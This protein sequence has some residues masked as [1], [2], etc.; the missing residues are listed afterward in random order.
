MFKRILMVGFICFLVVGCSGNN[1]KQEQTNG[2]KKQVITLGA[3]IIEKD[4]IDSVKTDFEE[5]GYKLENKVFDDM[6]TPNVA[7]QDGEI[8]A[9]FYQFIPYLD[10][11]NEEHKANLVAFSTP[12]YIS[13]VLAYSTKIEKIEELPDGAVIAINNDTTNRARALEFLEELDVIKLNPDAKYPTKNDI[14]ENKKNI[15]VIEVDDATLPTILPDVDLSL[16]YGLTA[17][18]SDLKLEDAI[19]SGGNDPKY[20]I[21]IAVNEKDKEATWVQ[22]LYSSFKTD[23]S[24]QFMKETFKGFVLPL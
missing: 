20:G 12:I 15:N 17:M 3:G 19:A 22:D 10:T 9:N 14:L 2:N 23:K 13:P 6:I 7:L 18:Y 4:I 5:K 1:D 8:D 21:V 11:F 16:M 24:Q